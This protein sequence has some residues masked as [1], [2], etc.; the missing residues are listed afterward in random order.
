MCSYVLDA[1]T[2][3]SC[4]FG[5]D[6]ACLFPF[7]VGVSMTVDGSERKEKLCVCVGMIFS[8]VVI[9]KVFV[10]IMTIIPF[11]MLEI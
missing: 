10:T 9:I 6:C 1:S 4:P 5:R 7:T 11:S 3:N 2:K 8:I